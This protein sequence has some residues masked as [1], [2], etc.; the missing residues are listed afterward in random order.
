MASLGGAAEAPD[1]L[2]E[3]GGVSDDEG[4]PR[5]LFALMINFHGA[6]KPTG[7]VRTWPHEMTREGIREQ[8]YLLSGSL[9]LVHDWY[10]AVLNCRADPRRFELDL[11]FLRPVGKEM[12]LYRDGA[13][14]PGCQIETRVSPPGGRQ[15]VRF[16]CGPGAGSWLTSTHPGNTAAGNTGDPPSRMR[17]ESDGLAGG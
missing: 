10:V 17:N 6:N 7:E 12:T 8:E 14:G 13:A 9:P 5:Y 11:S 4:M 15:A 2:T 16:P 3:S 1:G